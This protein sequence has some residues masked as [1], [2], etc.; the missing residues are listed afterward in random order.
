VSGSTYPVGKACLRN[1]EIDYGGI[2][3]PI[4]DNYVNLLFRKL[5]VGNYFY[6][7]GD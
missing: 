5:E 7:F 3:D 1:K 6:S 4:H 2:F